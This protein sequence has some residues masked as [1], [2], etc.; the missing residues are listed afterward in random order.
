MRSSPCW[1]VTSLA[2]FFRVEEELTS[3]GGGGGGGSSPPPNRLQPPSSQGAVKR[4]SSRAVVG[5]SNSTGRSSMM[6][7]Q[8]LSGEFRSQLEEL[9]DNINTTSP[10]YIR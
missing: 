8:T 7:V 9:M 6:K 5:R 3:M 4:M 1:L 2:D 10:H